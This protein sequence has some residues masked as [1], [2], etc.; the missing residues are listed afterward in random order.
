VRGTYASEDVA[1][2]GVIAKVPM[3]AAIWWVAALALLF[4]VCT[5]QPRIAAALH[6]EL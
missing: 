6:N 5:M 3:A 4:I 1:A 2:G